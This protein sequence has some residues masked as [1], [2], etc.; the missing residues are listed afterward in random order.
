MNATPK[1]PVST[2]EP[3]LAYA[4]GTPGRLELKQSLKELSA[5]QIEI[6]LVIGGKEVRTGKTSGAVMPHCHHHVLA[7]VHQAGPA[8]VR[9]AIAAA[10]EA[11]HDWSTWD[12][13]RRAAV[14]LKAGELLA[15]R[16]R[17]IVN[18]ATM[19]GQSKTAHQAEIDAACELID[20][21]RFNPHYAERLYTEQPISATATWNYLDY[22]PL[23][24]FVYAITPFNFTSIGGNLP[25]APA[26][27]GNTVVWKPAGTAALSNYF[28]MRLLAEAGLP[29]GVINFVP[30]PSVQVSER[31]LADRAFAGIHFTG[32][33]EVFQ[34]L[35]KQ[36]AANLTSYAAYPRAVGET[37]GKDFILAHPSADPDVLATGMVRGAF[38]YQGQKCSAA[39]RAYVPDALWSQVRDRMLEML[40][41]MKVGDPAD[42]RNFMG[43]VIDRKAFDKITAY[44][45]AA[46]QAPGVKLVFGGG[47]RDADGYFIHPTLLQVE[48]PRYRTMCEEIFGPVLSVH[49]Y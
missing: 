46:K 47:A 28:I 41:E 24:G 49:V 1:I 3:V 31:L 40:A 27:M 42:F 19:L 29:P 30:G 34:A 25:T 4:P 20:F 23:E 10:G 17:S 12:Q 44:I 13:G 2:N 9:A 21:F 5:H 35:W 15:T 11:W 22:R 18:A 37:G 45:D 7:K 48:D 39:S 26:I 16:Y 38:E 36:S 6:P 32:S 43:A 33:T 8:E 14:F